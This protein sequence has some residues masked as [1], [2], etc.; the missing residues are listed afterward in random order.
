MENPLTFFKPFGKILIFG[1]VL[2]ALICLWMFSTVLYLQKTY[3]AVHGGKS[4]DKVRTRGIPTGCKEKVFNYEDCSKL[5]E[6]LKG[7]HSFFQAFR[8]FQDQ[9]G[10]IPKQPCQTSL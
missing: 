9:I 6:I 2:T 8:S 3:S 10:E 7:V 1:E 4:S 5:E